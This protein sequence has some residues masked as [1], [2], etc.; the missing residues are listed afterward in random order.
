[1]R[2]RNQKYNNKKVTRNGELF[3]SKK[4]A[5]M[6]ATLV[7]LQREGKIRDL[8]LKPIY[9]LLPAFTV[10][11][12]G[13]VR[14]IRAATF[15]PDYRFFDNEQNRLRIVDCKGMR[16]DVYKLKKKLFDWQHLSEGLYIEETI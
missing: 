11:K 4:E 10:T 3:D 9:E 8:E 7:R 14:K 5:R 15:I 2:K 16:T 12:S 1:M 13:K 6:Y